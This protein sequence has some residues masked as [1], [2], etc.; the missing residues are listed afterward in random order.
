MKK[1]IQN[2]LYPLKKANI[3]DLIEVIITIDDAQRKKPAADPLIECA[4]RLGVDADN[5]VYVGDSRIDIKAGR[6]AGMKTVGVLTGLDDYDSLMEE[7]PDM[8]INSLVD[9]QITSYGLRVS[10]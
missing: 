5:C 9:L 2:K 6:A 7:G 3:D 8:V 10:L 1:N 4:K